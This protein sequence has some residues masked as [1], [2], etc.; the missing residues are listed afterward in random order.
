MIGYSVESRFVAGGILGALVGVFAGLPALLSRG[1]C[2]S[3]ASVVISA[4]LVAVA[5]WAAECYWMAGSNAGFQLYYGVTT[6]C[7]GAWIGF[8]M[9]A[10]NR[11]IKW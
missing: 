7:I 1:R 11:F 9:W 8:W 4:A 3:A 6:A 5:L 2:I 10:G